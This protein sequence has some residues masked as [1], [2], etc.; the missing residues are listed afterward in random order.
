MNIIETLAA[1]PW[2]ERLGWT[3]LHFLWE[4]AAIAAVYAVARARLARHADPNRRYLLACAALVVMVMAPAAT[5]YRLAPADIVASAPDRTAT[6][7]GFR[8]I[9]PT[10]VVPLPQP[11]RA[12]VPRKPAPRFLPWVV[13]AWMLGAMVFG[14]RLLGGWAA[15]A[16]ARS[17]TSRPA[18]ADW[19]QTLDRLK[20][21]LGLTRPVRLLVSAWVQTPAVVGWLRPVVLAPVGAL[22]GLPVAYVES[23]LMHELAHIRRQD[24]LVNMVQCAAEALLFYHPAVWWISGQIRAE[25]E[26]CCDDIAVRMSGDVLTYASALAELEA[27]RAGLHLALAANGGSLADRIARLLGESRPASGG[28]VPGVVIGAALLLAAFGLFGQTQERPAFQVA[29]V[30]LNA[31]AQPR[32]MIVRPQPGGRLTTHNARVSQLIENAY[33]VQAYQIVGGPEWINAEGY[34]IE[35]KPDH[36]I[37]RAEVW[38]MLQTLLADRFKLAIHR[39]TRELP[40]YALVADKNGE[41]LPVSKEAD[42]LAADPASPPPNANVRGPCGKILIDMSPQGLKMLGRSVDMAM[43]IGMLAAVLDRPVIDKTGFTGKTDIAMAF[44]PDDLTRGLPGAGGSHDPGGLP[45]PSDPNRPNIMAALQEQ[46]G[47]KLVST[48]GPVEV[49]VID[50]VERPSAN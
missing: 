42:C 5:W 33:Q 1:Q 19:Q 22:S 11:V 2:V 38:L 31:E 23:L 26:A 6:I 41:R 10:P 24:Y 49:L 36:D 48:K 13:A 30:K 3:L 4:G 17:T 8:A 16:G 20:E 34:D 47:L 43:L 44:T 18:S 15:A 9:T 29:S 46:L 50:R 28:I 21:R 45:L 27:Q 14:I 7:P 32:S 25:R 12:T 40:V 39:D 37:D 35:A